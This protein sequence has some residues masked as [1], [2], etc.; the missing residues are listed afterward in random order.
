MN[1]NSKQSREVDQA[2]RSGFILLTVNAKVSCAR[3]IDAP[4]E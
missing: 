4:K 3:M 1:Q 2:A